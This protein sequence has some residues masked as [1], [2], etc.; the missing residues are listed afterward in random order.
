MPPADPALLDVP[1]SLDTPRLILRALGPGDGLPFFAAIEASREHLYPF[2]PAVFNIATP[3]QAER[4]ARLA[5][6]QFQQR[7][8][9]RYGIWLREGAQFTGTCALHYA[10]WD[11][12]KFELGCWT[13][14]AHAGHAYGREAVQGLIALAFDTLAVER[15]EIRFDH[16]NTASQYGAEKLGFTFEARLR[17]HNRAADGALVDEMV[18]AM[19]R[20]DSP[21]RKTNHHDST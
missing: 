8:A 20:Q 3:A 18:Y 11:I 21:H 1:A 17:A 10:N 2:M 16:R 19:L 4:K 14:A 12:P 13:H 6:S 15:L 7:Q 5:W 9:F